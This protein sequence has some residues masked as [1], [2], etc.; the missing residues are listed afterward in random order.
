M[1]LPNNFPTWLYHFIHTREMYNS[2]SSSTSSPTIGIISLFN[3]SHS[4]GY[5]VIFHCGFNLQFPTTNDVEHLFIWVLSLHIFFWKVCVKIFGIL[6]ILFC[7]FLSSYWVGWVIYTHTA[8]SSVTI[9]CSSKGSI[10]F[11]DPKVLATFLH[12]A[13]PD[14]KNTLRHLVQ[15]CTINT[16]YI[17]AIEATAAHNNNSHPLESVTLSFLPYCKPCPSAIGCIWTLHAI[18]STE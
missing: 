11:W 1:K 10:R 9:I 17:L 18:N 16:S 14:E 5:E 6:K 4:S 8:K 3:F 15:T 12:V 7:F 2:F 13:L